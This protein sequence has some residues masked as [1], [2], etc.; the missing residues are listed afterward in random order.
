M[1]SA[2]QAWALSQNLASLIRS[3]LKPQLRVRSGGSDLTWFRWTETTD[4]LYP[5]NGRAPD[6]SRSCPYVFSTSRRLFSGTD[7]KRSMT[8]A[9]SL[10]QALQLSTLA[11]RTQIGFLNCGTQINM[12]PRCTV[13]GEPFDNMAYQVRLTTSAHSTCYWKLEGPWQG[14]C[15]THRARWLQSQQREKSL[16]ALIEKLSRP[17]G[18]AA[19]CPSI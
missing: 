2:L 4:P 18:S 15:Q 7:L 6:Q 10:L 11:L 1:Q 12:F 19:V 9:Q 5:S 8:F 13:L 17:S 16:Q 3:T 14:G